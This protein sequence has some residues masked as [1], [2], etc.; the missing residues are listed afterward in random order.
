MTEIK[1]NLRYLLGIKKHRRAL[2]FI[3]FFSDH[4]L[5]YMKL[6]NLYFVFQKLHGS[7][8]NFHM[9]ISEPRCFVHLKRHICAYVVERTLA[10]CLSCGY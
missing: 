9:P 7:F 8:E 3:L 6:F 1:K 5:Q 2:I 4:I 10:S